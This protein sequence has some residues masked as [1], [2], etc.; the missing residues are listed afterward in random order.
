MI[1]RPS[2]QTFVEHFSKIHK[3]NGTGILI[4]EYSRLYRI[5]SRW[6]GRVDPGRLDSGR[7]D[8]RSTW[9]AFEERVG[10]FAKFVFQVSRD[11]CVAFP[12]G[13]MGMSAVW[14]CGI[15]WSLTYYFFSMIRVWLVPRCLRVVLWSLCVPW[16]WNGCFSHGL[17]YFSR[18][19]LFR[20]L[21]YPLIISK[22]A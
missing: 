2:P 7:L 20:T 21:W 8:P 18:K 1:D 14:D 9:P 16:W 17:I 19:I 15:S 22:Y 6:P 12:R 11:C 5:R 13:A 10:C 3:K 4:I